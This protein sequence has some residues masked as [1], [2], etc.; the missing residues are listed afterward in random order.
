VVLQVLH[1]HDRRNSAGSSTVQA[2]Y[3]GVLSLYLLV[4]VYFNTTA[5]TVVAVPVGVGTVL[6]SE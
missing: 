6:S 3:T 1:E 2:V 4:Y 5:Y